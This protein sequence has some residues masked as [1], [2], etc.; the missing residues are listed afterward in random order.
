[1]LG[2]RRRAFHSST[3]RARFVSKHCVRVDV[4]I[5]RY[6]VTLKTLSCSRALPAILTHSASGLSRKPLQAAQGM[7]E[8]ADKA[9]ERASLVADACQQASTNVQTVASAAGELSTSITE[10][11]Q[12]VAQAAQVAAGNHQPVGGLDDLVFAEA[13]SGAAQIAESARDKQRAV[14]CG[15]R[16]AGRSKDTSLVGNRGG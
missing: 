4:S 7:S 15:W 9:T 3:K 14:I 12:R 1:M 6:G 10:I 16:K 2:N 11:S 8:T 13:V 5:T